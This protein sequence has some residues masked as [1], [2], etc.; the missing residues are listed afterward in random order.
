MKLSRLLLSAVAALGLTCAAGA[1][2]AQSEMMSA[3]WAKAACDAWNAEPVLT[4]RLVEPG[5]V[6]NDANRGFKVIQI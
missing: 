2:H 4:D 5:W 3:A 1:A 6:K